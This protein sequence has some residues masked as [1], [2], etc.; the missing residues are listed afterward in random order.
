[1]VLS[2]ADRQATTHVEEHGIEEGDV[3]MEHYQVEYLNQEAAFIF[4]TKLSNLT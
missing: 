2:H 4:N 3:V 1:M